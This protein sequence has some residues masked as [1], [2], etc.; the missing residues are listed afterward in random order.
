METVN[1]DI[2]CLVEGNLVVDLDINNIFNNGNILSQNFGGPNSNNNQCREDLEP[3]MVDNPLGEGEYGS[4]HINT[5]SDGESDSVE[6]S[7][8]G[9]DDASSR[10]GNNLEES[11]AAWNLRPRRNINYH[12]G[13]A[14][15]G[16]T[17]GGRGGRGEEGVVSEHIVKGLPPTQLV[18]G[19]AIVHHPEVA[20]I[21]NALRAEE[22]AARKGKVMEKEQIAK[23]M[24]KASGKN[25]LRVLVKEKDPDVLC[26]AE[27][28]IEVG[29]ALNLW[30]VWKRN[31]NIPT[32]IA[33]S[34]QHISVSIK[35]D[36]T[37]VQISFVHASSFRA[38][39]RSLWMKLMA[40]SPQS[41]TPWVIMGDFNATLQSHEKRGSG[42]FSMGSAAEFGA[43]VDACVMAQVPSSGMN[44]TWSN[45]RRRGN[46]RAV[47]DRSF[48][49]D[50]W[51]SRFQDCA[52]TVLDRIASDHAPIMVTSALSQRPPNAPF[53]FH[54]FWIDHT[55]FETVV[56]LDI[57]ANGLDD[58]SFA[59]E[60]NAK[61]SL[62]KAL[63]LHEKLW[64]EKAKIRWMKQG[65]RNSKFFHLSAKMRR[66]RNTIRCLKKQ[67]GTIVEGREQL[68]DYIVQFFEDFHKATPTIDH[69]DLLNS[70]P[71]VLQPNDIFFLDSIPGDEEIK[72]AIWEL[73]PDSS[74]GP[75]EFT[76]DF[77]RRCWNIVE[78]EVCSAT[79]HF[80]S[81]SHMPKGINNN[82]LVLI[83][84]VEGA[85]SLDKFRP[86]CMG[87]FFCKIISKVMALRLEKFLPRLISEEQGAFQKGKLIHSNISLASELA[88]MMFASTR[89]GG[90]GLKIDIKKAYATISWHFLFLV[91]R[92]FGFS[93]KWV[94]WL[95]QML[96]ST[97]ISIMVNEGP[98][99]YFD[100]ERGLRQGDPISPLLFIIAEEVLSRGIKS[101]IHMNKLKPLQGLRGVP[102]PSH[103][104]FADDIFI[105]SNATMRTMYELRKKQ[106][107]LGKNPSCQEAVH[108]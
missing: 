105:F 75:D 59:R 9:E 30:I 24:K 64:A 56:Q 70:I 46:V 27:P 99:G 61:T 52:Q 1:G 26:I 36:S 97:K 44:F 96:I 93:E 79:R 10:A 6:G 107:L 34:E 65:D 15:R 95:H 73:D 67:D 80:F 69:V 62:I 94:T 16:S 55:D 77:F 14:G 104:L 47:L 11:F 53:R 101:L 63:D 108:L 45:N 102:A 66:I 100:V 83:P 106:A 76:G 19:R 74:P 35:W 39:R 2:N 87:N 33:E 60:A 7:E 38:E 18:G 5:I 91:L 49:N 68:G 23:G 43:M 103:I 12:G 31:L 4:D 85:S 82:F 20:A 51:I 78:R 3:N 71:T 86:L 89:G 29:K 84:K 13:H 40:D 72:K 41:P 54:K 81:S 92:K 25:A 22:A 8:Q 90:L 48:C 32:V 57:E 98:Q 42:N 50:E 88:N 37:T 17:R 58:H 21:D 28:M